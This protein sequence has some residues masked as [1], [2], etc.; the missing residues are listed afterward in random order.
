MEPKK[1]EV[2]T[3]VGDRVE[4]AITVGHSRDRAIT[5]SVL[6]IAVSAFIVRSYLPLSFLFK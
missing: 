6:T 4:N 5:G 2:C 1:L 3:R